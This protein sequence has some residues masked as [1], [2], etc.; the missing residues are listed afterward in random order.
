MEIEKYPYQKEWE[1]YISRARTF[2][3]IF[4][5]STPILSAIL[6]RF[7]FNS[8]DIKSRNFTVVSLLI[9]IIACGVAGYKLFYWKCPKCAKPFL[10]IPLNFITKRNCQNCGLKRFKGSDLERPK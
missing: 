5:V 9:Y 8:D 7:I 4:F 6:L 2:W 3:R 1:E 10:K